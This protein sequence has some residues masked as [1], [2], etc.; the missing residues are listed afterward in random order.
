MKDKNQSGITFQRQANSIKALA[1]EGKLLIKS[2]QAYLANTD[3]VKE[4]FDIKKT[5][6]FSMLVSLYEVRLLFSVK[7]KLNKT[8]GGTG[9][10]CA[11]IRSDESKGKPEELVFEKKLFEEEEAGGQVSY[12]EH[13]SQTNREELDPEVAKSIL[14]ELAKELADKDLILGLRWGKCSKDCEQKA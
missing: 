2:L 10:I 6:P 11:Y 3:G 7:I 8:G 13:K 9:F 4:H 12:I 5:C 1:G 14:L